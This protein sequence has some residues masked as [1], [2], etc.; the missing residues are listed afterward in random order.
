M[1]TSAPPPAD[2]PFTGSASAASERWSAE[3]F[4][5]ADA[6]KWM[7]AGIRRAETARQ[8]ANAGLAPEVA[9]PWYDLY[10]R[11]PD[12]A[13]LWLAAGFDSKTAGPWIPSQVDPQDARVCV[14]AGLSPTNFRSVSVETTIVILRLAHELTAAKLTFS[15]IQPFLDRNVEPFRSLRWAEWCRT[16]SSDTA[17]RWSAAGFEPDEAMRWIDEGFVEPHATQ[18]WRQQGH[19]PSESAEWI[20]SSPIL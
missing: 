17:Y 19:R 7:T 11:G 14:A 5:I 2:L 20:W 13:L 16:N 12:E 3:G 6:S 1:N 10:V 4:D 15:E 8:W 9:G 18:I